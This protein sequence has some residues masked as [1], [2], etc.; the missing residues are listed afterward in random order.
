MINESKI[1]RETHYFQYK[2]G[3]NYIYKGGTL[4]IL[5]KI[6]S[7]FHKYKKNIK[8]QENTIFPVYPR[9][10]QE[11]LKVNLG[12]PE[13]L[14][15]IE[16]SKLNKAKFL[17]HTK[18]I[19]NNQWINPIQG[20][21]FGKSSA[22]LS[23]Y[24]YQP[25]NYFECSTISQDPLMNNVFDIL[26]TT[27]FSNGGILIVKDKE[28]N[29]DY[30]NKLEELSEI[31]NLN[32]VLQQAVK[33]C[34]VFGGCLVYMD[35][36]ESNYLDQPIDE[37]KYKKFRGFRII[38]PSLCCSIDVNVVNALSDDY[39]EP[40]SWYIK[41]EGIIH[42]SRFIKFEWN[43]PPLSMKPM[44]MYFG[45]P[46]TQLI[47]QDIANANLVTQGLANLVN[48]V[49]KTFLKTDITLFAS[50][51]LP[52]IMN[53]FEAMEMIGNNHKIFPISNNEDIIQLNTPLSNYQ[54]IVETFFNAIACKTGIPRSKLT[55]AS[56]GG[57]NANTSQV[58]S[59]K[60]FIDKI[61]TIRQGLIKS[62]LLKM[63]QV[64]GA[65]ID[66]T[67]REFDYKFNSLSTPTDLEKTENISKNVDI[68]LKLKEFG[69]DDEKCLEW[70]DKNKILNLGI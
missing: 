7:Y 46:M 38:E 19:T 37:S 10:K 50:D 61:E 5:S 31:Y 32:N 26:T 6:L 29:K 24:L 70:L 17:K 11:K 60:N 9:Y 47:K 45:M 67:I 4:K 58:E 51:A 52:S 23:A 1:H 68:A 27:P 3:G 36:G 12:E 64:I 48:D 13:T 54:E 30:L 2:T 41:G 33:N 63:Y 43:V 22:N 8:E 14:A 56:V 62:R 34:F 59:N 55:G 15:S 49:R 35:F 44:C 20:I 65:T 21:N 66:G 69:V 40:E 39:M 16:C 28:N 25:V 42:K 57:L 18:N 53:R